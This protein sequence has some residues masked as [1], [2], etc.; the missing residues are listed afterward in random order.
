MPKTFNV[1]GD[2]KPGEHYMVNIDR[3]L[4]EMKKMMDDG[5]YFTV[6]RARQYGKTTT[7][8]ALSRYLRQ[9]Y[10]VVS[11]DF[12]AI[13]NAKF[14]SEHAFSVTFA[15]LFLKGL[16]RNE[17]SSKATL[18]SSIGLLEQRSSSERQD[19][20]LPELF[21]CLSDICASSDRPLALLIDEVDSAA[22]SPVFLSFLGQ[23]RA[24]YIDRDVSPAFQSVIL[25]SVRDIKNLS[26][27]LRS[28]NGANSPWNI[29]ADFSMDM[30]LPKE[31]IADMLQEYEANRHTGMD[32]DEIAG[33]IFDHT[34]G[35]PFLVSRLCKLMDDAAH[36]LPSAWTNE[37]FHEA[38]RKLL[39]EKNTLFESLMGKLADYPELNAMLRTQLFTGKAIAYNSDDP[40]IDT[41]AMFGFLRNRQGE[42]VIANRI[43]ETRLYNYYL[44][45]AEMQRQDIYKTS[46]QD[47]SQF[48]VDG[49]LNM[50]LILEKFA[51]HF[52]DLYGDRNEAFL[53]EEGRKFF[54]L[55]LRPIINGV[56]NYYIES[57]TREL[58]RTDVIVDYH[59]EQFVIEMKIWRGEE[60]NR[61]GERQLAQYLD[62][63]HV[64]EGYMVSFNFNRNKQVGVR[65]IV[66]DGKVLVEAVV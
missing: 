22:D 12:Q 40:A 51:T 41:A 46:L 36:G 42:A 33:L 38:L 18:L 3:R 2:C 6:N 31:G 64:K 32:I 17:L 52:H 55:Y 35:Y 58:R 45:T 48:L 13:S 27:K 59:G 57:R 25:A 8:R 53:E 65:E 7:L 5:K 15:K 44:S 9:D 26:H 54:L 4:S 49:H 20:E 16:K 23:L 11:L 43:F 1:T 30:G 56:G 19:F 50:R 60:Y 39:S 21:E 66:V 28:G 47:K 63:C 10:Y 37:G 34:S 61:R 14:Q 24:S 62:D 29:A